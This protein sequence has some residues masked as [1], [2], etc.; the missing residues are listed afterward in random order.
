M[1]IPKFQ[2]IVLFSAVLLIFQ[3]FTISAQDSIGKPELSVVGVE[4]GNRESAKNYLLP[5]HSP[6]VEEDG[7][8]GYFFYNEWGTQVMRLTVASVD[9]PY[10]ITGIEVF[11]VGDSYQ[12]KHY[13]DTKNGLMMTENGIF[14]GFRQTAMNLIIGIRNA[15]KRNTIGPDA[16]IDIKGEPTKREKIDEKGEALIYEIPAV[17]VKDSETDVKYVARYEFSGKKLKRFSLKII[18]EDEKLAKN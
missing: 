6:R 10:F 9:D 12:K 17:K 14:I 7:R 16:V 13:Q 15:G 1:R 8:A 2:Q 4:L 3:T 5:G 11:A 18:V